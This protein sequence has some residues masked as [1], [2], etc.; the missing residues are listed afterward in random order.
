MHKALIS[1]SVCF[2]LLSN[3]VVFKQY[4]ELQSMICMFFNWK[5]KLWFNFKVFWS[6]T[7]FPMYFA[8]GQYALLVLL[9]STNTVENLFAETM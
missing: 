6:K 3:R 9:N 4:S 2:R 8:I 5:S 1:V 7:I